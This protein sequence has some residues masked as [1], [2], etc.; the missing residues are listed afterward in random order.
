MKKTLLISIALLATSAMYAGTESSRGIFAKKGIKER[1]ELVIPDATNRLVLTPQQAADFQA[2]NEKG[3][4][5]ETPV[6]KKEKSAVELNIRK[7]DS[8]INDQKDQLKVLKLNAQIQEAKK[9]EREMLK[10]EEKKSASRAD[11]RG[12]EGRP[13]QWDQPF[14]SNADDATLSSINYQYSIS[15][16]ALAQYGTRSFTYDAQG[17]A[18]GTST[19]Y[20]NKD[21]ILNKIKLFS[22][23]T[24]PLNA[25]VF[26]ESLSTENEYKQ[27]NYYLD[28]ATGARKDISV[29]KYTYY[30]EQEVTRV[31]KGLDKEGNMIEYSR[32]ESEFDAQGRPTVTISYQKEKETS[33]TCDM[34]SR[35]VEYE[36]L[37]NG[38]TLRTYSIWTPN[39]DTTAY[40]WVYSYKQMRGTDSEGYYNYEYD[41][42]DTTDSVWYGSNKYKEYEPEDG[43]E[44]KFIRYSWSYTDQE[45]VYSWKQSLKYNS[46]GYT[47]YQ[48]YFSY[49]TEFKSFYPVEKHYYT[50]LADTLVASEKAFY[51]N[52]PSSKEQLSNTESLIYYGNCYDFTYP[53]DRE[54]GVVMSNYPDLDRPYKSQAYSY[55]SIDENGKATWVKSSK[56]ECEYK[57]FKA[58]DES[59]LAFHKTDIKYYSV[60]RETNDWTLYYEEKYDFDDHGSQIL[61]EDYE[62]DTVYYR[63]AQKYKYLT[64]DENE[65]R[66][67]VLDADWRVSNGFFS[68]YYINENNYDKNGN[69]TLYSY[70]DSWSLETKNWTYGY[71][72]VYAYNEDD[73]Q[74]LY[75]SYSWNAE[76]GS[77]YETDKTVRGYDKNNRLVKLEYFTA[78]WDEEGKYIGVVPYDYQEA[79]QDKDG[80]DT[81]FYYFYDW[82]LTT[83]TWGT[84]IKETYEYNANGDMVLCIYYTYNATTGIW[85]KDAYEEY[86]YTADGEDLNYYYYE[87][88][89]QGNAILMEQEIAQ[90]A[91]DGE[92]TGYT[93]S[94]LNDEGE[95]VYV[96]KIEY[97]N[98]AATGTHTTYYY[99]WNDLLSEWQYSRK[100][101]ITNDTSG[102]LLLLANYTWDSNNEDWV[103]SGMKLEYSYD[104]ENGMTMGTVWQWDSDSNEWAGL[105]KWT[106]ATDSKGRETYYESYDWDSY[107]EA[108]KGANKYEY[109]YDEY[110]N[111][112]MEATYSW[113]SY[114]QKWYGNRKYEYEFDA[115]GNEIMYAYYYYDSQLDEWY[116]SSMYKNY[117]DNNGI[118]HYEYSYWDY[119][120]KDWRGSYKYDYYDKGNSFMRANY[121]WDEES[122][123]WVGYSKYE[124]T[125]TESYDDY[126]RINYDWDASKKDWTYTTKEVEKYES[127]ATTEKYDYTTY[128]WD[129]KEWTLYSHAI[130]ADVYNSKNN[131]DYLTYVYQLYNSTSKAWVADYSIKYVYVYTERTGV[132]PIQV[133]S[134]ISVAEGLITVNAAAGS[135]VSISSM[136]G[137]EIAT[138]TGSMVAPVAPGI[139][140]ITIDGTTTKVSVR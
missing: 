82:D 42:Y 15:N 105:S 116:G 126:T 88:D 117:T 121:E 10:K 6:F 7:A 37:A 43:S 28:P 115:D 65:E 76:T 107:K 30:D 89:S 66:F 59:Y 21:N 106:A 17:R 134:R 24:L 72:Y 95:W 114:D 22:N 70:N 9:I 47:T 112:I 101:I 136:A 52:S 11:I 111:T 1:P 58:Y 119:E 40:S 94:K 69:Q 84:K 100:F 51:Y 120:K 46:R 125:Y 60:D 25:K 98:D 29:Y 57:L 78:A 74:T 128:K 3:I 34:P 124:Y 109:A 130:E 36:Y 123:S 132:K 81:V 8:K 71:K 96:H 4:V 54:L 38:L 87:Y 45:W 19:I 91:A 2:A 18:I 5:P 108:W 122:W 135:N 26:V 23:I 39:A 41:R 110:D 102:R 50:Y 32:V 55:Y 93:Y 77:W 118:Y 16:S 56:E 53:T 90:V 49:S 33:T 133:K 138:G 139:Y 31:D 68:P 12:T 73:Y 129:G 104:D 140:L 103:G 86:T 63:S 35:K 67:C 27:E 13:Y 79:L 61:Y 75:E 127:T 85:E 137:G 64:I 14:N 44:Y 83:S 80:N 131:M 97:K 92:I 62:G 48:D 99:T 20:E 113:S